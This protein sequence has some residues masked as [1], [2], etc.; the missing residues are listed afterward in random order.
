MSNTTRGRHSAPSTR[1]WLGRRSRPACGPMPALD[2]VDAPVCPSMD[3]PD[4]HM[5][6]RPETPSEVYVGTVLAKSPYRFRRGDE[7]VV[8][9][10]GAHPARLGR[11][12]I[13]DRVTGTVMPVAVE[14]DGGTVYFDE[15][16]LTL[17]RRPLSAEDTEEFPPV[18]VPVSVVQVEQVPGAAIGFWTVQDDT[19]VLDD[20][21]VDVVLM[22]G[23][24]R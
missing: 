23:A 5:A 16:D 22:G 2:V 12:G 18:E 1:R 6:Q 21:D 4:G 9:G 15:V 17:T 11:T 8:T 14:I 10:Y 3:L 7:V 19:L 20:E 13:V 24:T